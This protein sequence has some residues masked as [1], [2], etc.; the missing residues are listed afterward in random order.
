MKGLHIL[1]TEGINEREV[2]N[3]VSAFKCEGEQRKEAHNKDAGK[4]R[5]FYLKCKCGSNDWTDNGR[6]MH[7]YECNGCGQFIEVYMSEDD[8]P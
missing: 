1:Y 5:I 3:E 8:R 2:T 4:G 7:E 6:M